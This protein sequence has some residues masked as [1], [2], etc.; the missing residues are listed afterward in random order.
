MTAAATPGR[1]AF[2]FLIVMVA[3]DMIAGSIVIP[4]TP[5]L[6]R[7]LAGGDDAAGARYVGLFVATWALMQFV[8]AP[9]LGGLSDRFGRRPVLLLSMLGLAID[10]VLMALAPT[11]AWLFVARLIS[12]AAASTMAAANAYIAD[13]TPPDDRAARFG[14]LGAAWGVGFILGPALGGL[15]GEIGPRA[16]FWG[17]A[18]F[19]A[20]NLLYGL[21]VLPESLPKDRRAA[22][23]LKL[24]NPFGALAY[25]A[26]KPGFLTLGAIILLGGLAHQ[27]LGSTWIPYVNYRFAWPNWLLGA[28]LALVGA[29][30]IAVQSLLVRPFVARFGERAA[31]CAGLAATALSFVV[32]GV[33]PWTWLFLA[34]IP[35]FAMGGLQEPGLQA[36]L[37]RQASPTEQGR[38]Q[39]ARAA[40]V[41]LTAI[42][43]PVLFTET[44]ARSIRDWQGWAPVGLAFYM[45]AAMVMAALG[46]AVAVTGRWRRADAAVTMEANEGR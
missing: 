28:S 31:M 5:A 9:I 16:P 41:A 17:A 24:S 3:L 2:R 1:N 36:L 29:C 33:S 4:V 26:T 20:V 12:G 43:G 8:F 21:F 6:V 37:T 10:C 39:G 18:A 13:V 15:L 32:Y 23:S 40:L 25:F 27:V 46:L 30:Y 11:L 19:C 45:A 35:I 38:L 44:F 42:V 22:F 14:M 7:D 34:I